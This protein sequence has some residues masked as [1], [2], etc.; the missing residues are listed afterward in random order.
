MIDPI[1]VIFSLVPPKSTESLQYPQYIALSGTMG[2]NGVICA[3]TS[4]SLLLFPISTICLMSITTCFLHAGC[5]LQSGRRKIRSS[6]CPETRR[7]RKHFHLHASAATTW[8]LGSKQTH[9]PALVATANEQ[10]SS[11]PLVG[12]GSKNKPVRSSF[13]R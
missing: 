1:W 10:R 2:A 13:N 11:E 4:Y 8:F 6:R 5:C 3:T 9:G 7:L 12:W